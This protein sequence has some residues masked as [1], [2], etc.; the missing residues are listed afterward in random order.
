V[1]ARAFLQERGNGE[2]RHEEELLRGEL[3]RRGI[4]ITLYTAKRIQRRQLPLAE[5]AFIAGDMDAMHGAMRQLG[6]P[7]PAPNDFPPSLHPFLHRRVW[8]S[9]LAAVEAA[10]VEG[11]SQAVFAKP[12]DRRKGFTGRVFASMDDLRDIGGVSRRQDVWCSEVVVWS[13][14]Y[15]V[16][17]N[18]TR[19]MGIDDYAGD[20]AVRLDHAIVESALE[21][22]RESGE[23]PCAFGIDFG[24]LASGQTALVEANDGFAL[25][26]YQIEAKPY[27]DLL[28]ARWAELLSTRAHARE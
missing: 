9:T 15:R 12:A 27:T 8:R 5:D 16:Y 21:T 22:F 10:V 14:E 19:I 25:G 17:V 20:A 28:M 24:V 26:A 18:G 4:P 13:A 2:L 7:I 6:I 1:F 23:A 11:R 3:E